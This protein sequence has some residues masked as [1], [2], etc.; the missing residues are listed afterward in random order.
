MIENYLAGGKNHPIP[1]PEH[2]PHEVCKGSGPY[3]FD[4]HGNPYIDMWMGYGALLLGHANEALIENASQLMKEGYFFSNTHTLEKIYAE[5][6]HHTIPSAERVRF[7]VTGSDAV[8]YAIRAA[9]AFTGR[10]KILSVYGGYHGVHEGLIPSKGVCKEVESSIEWVRFNAPEAL[11]QK[12]QTK[13]FAAFLL[14]PILANAGCTPPEDGY[15]QQVRDICTKTNTLL[16]FD[17]V[18]TGFRIRPGGAQSYYNVKPDIS[19][20]S[21]AIANGFP[22]SA[23]V[24]RK[25]I[26]EQFIPTGEVFFAGTFS[27]HPLSLSAAVKVLEILASN[28]IHE[29]LQEIGEDIRSHIRQE[30]ESLRL[31]ACVQGIASMFT[32]AFG[33]K[34][35]KHGLGATEYNRELYTQFVQIMAKRGL[36]FPPLPTETV[37]LS[38][39]HM[40]L[41]SQIKEQISQGLQE[42]VEIYP[43]LVMKAE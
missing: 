1:Y 30:I 36:L 28:P 39:V 38:V 8:A 6:L 41:V 25:D 32:I 3:V 18:V 21:K 35:F 4:I 11:E 22:L 42:L 33:C 12:L 13:A 2:Y 20:F 14:E 29:K 34:S 16:I 10:N 23:V 7:A 5:K 31:H 43:Q 9:K 19:T 24:G 37:F 40:P 27:A 26:L 17:E 15:L